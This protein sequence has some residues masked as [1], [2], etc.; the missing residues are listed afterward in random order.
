MICQARDVLIEQ[1]EAAAM[2]YREAVMG[3]SE[4]R[5]TAYERAW[6]HAEDVRRLRNGARRALLDHEHEHGCGLRASA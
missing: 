3:M 1:Y 5:G 2:A 4:L 6:Q